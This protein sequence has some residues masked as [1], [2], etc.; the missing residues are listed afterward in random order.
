MIALLRR[1][2]RWTVTVLFAVVVLLYVWAILARK[3]HLR[4]HSSPDV[5]ETPHG[6]ERVIE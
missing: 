1:R 4:A 2:H 3:A 6:T 5:R